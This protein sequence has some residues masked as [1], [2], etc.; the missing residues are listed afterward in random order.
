[1]KYA[2]H[3]CFGCFL[4]IIQVVFSNKKTN[5]CLSLY[6]K[7]INTSKNLR[8]FSFAHYILLRYLEDTFTEMLNYVMYA[9]YKIS[10]LNIV[11]TSKLWKPKRDVCNDADVMPM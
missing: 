7:E 2:F 11:T 9:K 8:I 5:K 4:R 3:Y 6:P 1:M 10:W